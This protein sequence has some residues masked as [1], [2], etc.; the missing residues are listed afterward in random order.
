MAA[1]PDKSDDVLTQ[2]L[3]TTLAEI[4]SHHHGTTKAADGDEPS[5]L[6]CCVICLEGISEA[7]CAL[8]CAHA[9]FDFLC[10]LSWLEQRPSCPLCKAPVQQVRYR[11]ANAA[12]R[13]F[14]VSNTTDTPPTQTREQPIPRPRRRRRTPS[15]AGLSRPADAIA[16]RRD[17]YR[18]NLYSLRTRPLPLPPTTP[19][20]PNPPPPLDIG[21]N[22]HSR[23]RLPPTPSDFTRT[24]HLVSRARLW[25]RRELQVFS[26]LSEPPTTTTP[27]TDTTTRRHDN[28]EFLL[29][30]IIAILKT[31]DVQGSAGEAAGML[32]DFLGRKHAA[33]FWH[34]LR[35]WLRSPAGTLGVWDREVRYPEPGGRKRRMG[36]DGEDVAEGA[37]GE[38]WEDEMGGRHW[39]PGGSDGRRGKRR[40]RERHA[41]GG[42]SNGR[43]E[44]GRDG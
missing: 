25:I 6:D 42:S 18:H 44:V 4:S 19:T 41:E 13:L 22:P 1:S 8:P 16:F 24:P 15:P 31:V 32:G 26:F 35:S 23:Y 10:L 12:E 5:A 9:N 14:P 28:A 34:E 17:I 29:E 43:T 36:G 38:E 39:R 20:V 2:V 7:C 40:R 11:D 21:T 33:L 37:E 30:Y 3:Q 27:T